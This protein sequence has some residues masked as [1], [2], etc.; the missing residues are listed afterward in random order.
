MSD[1]IKLPQ[2]DCAL[3][4]THNQHK[5]M[6]QTLTEFIGNSEALGSPLQWESDEAK[7]ES[8]KTGELWEMQW[9]PDTPVA[10]FSVAAPTLNDLLKFAMKED[11]E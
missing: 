6:Y 3:Y 2:H 9:Y 11:T 5:D 8:I 1:A 7:A 10:F 4:I